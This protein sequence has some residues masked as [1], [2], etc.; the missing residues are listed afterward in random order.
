M[1]LSLWSNFDVGVVVGAGIEDDSVRSLYSCHGNRVGVLHCWLL[2]GC[3]QSLRRQISFLS[4]RDCLFGLSAFIVCIDIFG[5]P[6]V[7]KV[8]FK[9][10]VTSSEVSSSSWSSASRRKFNGGSF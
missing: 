8:S 7:A 3:L 1:I 6:N 4:A 9:S 10:F 5:V 2:Q